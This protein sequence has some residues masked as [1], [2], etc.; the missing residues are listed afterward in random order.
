M[1]Y[2]VMI[3]FVLFMIVGSAFAES[4]VLKCTTSDGRDTV[5]LTID[6]KKKEL[7]WGPTKYFIININDKYISAYKRTEDIVGGEIWVIDRR[8]GEYKRGLVGIMFSEGEN[9]EQA[10][11]KAITSS[12]QCVKQQF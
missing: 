12:G 1:R 10:R 3:M 5:D 2:L 4:V 8:S 11:L 6:L 9:P 7:R